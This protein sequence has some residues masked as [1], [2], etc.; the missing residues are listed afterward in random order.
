MAFLTK[1]TA[2]A[3][4]LMAAVFVRR[5][6]WPL[7]AIAGGTLLLRFS[8]LG[9][10]VA[11]LP[12]R[13]L[14]GHLHVIVA[15]ALQYAKKLIWPWPLAPEYHLAHPPAAWVVF[16]VGC[17]LAAWAATRHK[18][19]R[20]ALLLVFLPL[21]PALASSFV[22]PAFRQ[23]Q[24]RFAYVAVLGVALLI[25]YATHHAHRFRRVVAVAAM[26]LLLIWSALSV[27][28][29][30]NWRDTETLWTH[31]L[32]V[33]PNSK[34]AVISL[35]YWYFTTGRLEEAQHIYEQGL[36]LRPSDPDYLTSHAAVRKLL[37]QPR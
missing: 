23:A 36:A 5:R 7:F 12:H 15:T 6:A 2:L 33:T 30:Q 25:G 35:G 21:T 27:A 11:S 16:A 13:S 10:G 8:T 34:T 29:I 14:L 18:E 26:A 32:R 24:D 4:P 31:T 28:A 37:E 1:E 22:L 19:A 9:L 20:L 17:A 3:L